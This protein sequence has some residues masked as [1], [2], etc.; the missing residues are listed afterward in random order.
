V[1][2]YVGDGIMAFFGYPAASLQAQSAT[3]Q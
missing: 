3:A 2:R 1:V